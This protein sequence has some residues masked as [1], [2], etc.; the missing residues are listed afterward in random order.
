V[1]CIVA[2]RILYLTTIGRNTP[3]VPCTVVFEDYEWKAV[4]AHIHR[5]PEVPA[6]PPKLR[7]M[8]K[9]IGRL[10]GHLGRKQDKMPGPM[11]MWR[12]LQRVPDFASMW[13]LFQNPTKPSLRS[14]RPRRN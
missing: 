3:E 6:A 14:R 9:M 7:E 5:T 1:D 11:T 13:L 4:W 10:G 2:W 8:V 12:G